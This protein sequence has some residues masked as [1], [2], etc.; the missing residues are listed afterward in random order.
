MDKNWSCI[1]KVT[2]KFLRD[3]IIEADL[4]L[5]R[6]LPM[7]KLHIYHIKGVIK[8]GNDGSPFSTSDDATGRTGR[9]KKERE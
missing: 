4:N 3:V 9:K 2:I 6:I 5:E 1:A 8:R 7:T